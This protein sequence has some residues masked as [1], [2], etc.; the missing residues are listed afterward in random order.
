MS[1]KTNKENSKTKKGSHVNID[2]LKGR[3]SNDQ[4][5]SHVNLEMSYEEK[6]ELQSIFDEVLGSHVNI[7]DMSQETKDELNKITKQKIDAVE[8]PEELSYEDK[9]IRTKALIIESV[10]QFG[11]E[12]VYIAFS[13]GKDSSV[14]MHIIH[15]IYPEIPIVF[16]NTGLELPEI[17][18]FVKKQRDV[19]NKNVAILKPRKTF[20]QVLEQ[21]GFPIISKEVSMSMSRYQ[22]AKSPRSKRLRLFGGFN[23]NT[24][25]M[26]KMGVI[27]KKWRHLRNKIKTTERCCDYFKKMP[28]VK[29]EKENKKGLSFVG[30]RVEESNLR[31]RSFRKMGCQAFNLKRPQSRPIMFWEEKDVNRYIQEN[32]VEICDVYYDKWIENPT[33]GEMLMVPAET[34]TGC[35]FC[36]YGL[37]LEDEENTRFHKLQKRHPKLFK[38]S[39]DKL[40]LREIIK[41]YT[42]IIFNDD[43][44]YPEYIKQKREEKKKGKKDKKNK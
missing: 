26:Q 14:L 30:V 15:S 10:E 4:K 41:E 8:N 43:P 44:R 12:K 32:N 3:I 38:Y 36:M 22:N 19:Y 39:M 16:A 23:I 24:N 40:G 17:V 9:L 42:G 37:H 13:G 11:L 33:T 25:K 28:F 29:Y 6:K 5:G 1:K 35:I 27:P 2:D 21:Y 31:R 20:K 7:N 34:R 18:A